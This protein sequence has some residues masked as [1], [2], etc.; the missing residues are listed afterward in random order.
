MEKWL[1]YERL[2][3]YE[4]KCKL[5]T[6][7]FSIQKQIRKQRAECIYSRLKTFTTLIVIWIN[8]AT[9]GDH[10]FHKSGKWKKT[11]RYLMVKHYV[12]QQIKWFEKTSTEKCP[13]CQ[14]YHQVWTHN[15]LIEASV[16]VRWDI[17]KQTMLLLF[18]WSTLFYQRSNR[19]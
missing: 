19:K 8:K 18:C 16:N 14:H 5:K 12:D 3:I 7:S 15:K 4:K 9:I 11:G 1:H 17:V 2:E 6:T 10:G 13:V